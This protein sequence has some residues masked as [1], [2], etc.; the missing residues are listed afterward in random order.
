MVQDHF[1]D[2]SP[3]RPLT[4]SIQQ[5]DYLMTSVN[6]AYLNKGKDINVMPN[7]KPITLHYRT[8]AQPIVVHQ[9]RL[10][11]NLIVMNDNQF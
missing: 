7:H 1:S 3:Y 2:H 9:T 6:Q 11:G 8:H 5:A 10:P 4:N